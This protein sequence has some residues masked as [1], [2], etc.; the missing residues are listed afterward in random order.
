MRAD[1]LEDWDG[2]TSA[3][4]STGSSGVMVECNSKIELS[5]AYSERLSDDEIADMMA[6][7]A[8][9]DAMF[10]SG[11]IS[12]TYLVAL[13]AAADASGAWQPEVSEA[14]AA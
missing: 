13:A 2:R 6:E 4:K 5:A 11:E 12:T 10:Q 9:V 1:R 3:K 14:T 8:R 7:A